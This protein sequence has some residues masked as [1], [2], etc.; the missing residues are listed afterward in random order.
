MNRSFLSN[1]TKEIYTQNQGKLFNILMVLPGNRAKLFAADALRSLQEKKPMILPD[2]LT[3]PEL[4]ELIS[5]QTIADTQDLLLDFYQTVKNID[6][7]I[8]LDQ[9]ILWGDTF[10][11]DFNDIDV[12]LINPKDVFTFLSESKAM[13]LWN[14]SGEALSKFQKRYLALFQRLYEYYNALQIKMNETGYGYQ[15]FVFKN[16][17]T[18][19]NFDKILSQWKKIIFCGFNAFSHSEKTI[20]ER[21]HKLGKL[22]TYWDIDNYYI[23]HPL[24][25]AGKFFRAYKDDFLGRKI[26]DAPQE[27]IKRKIKIR[28]SGIPGDVAQAKVA[29]NIV[30]DLKSHGNTA[31]ILNDE[32]LL[33]PLLNALPKVAEK[34]NVTMGFPAQQTEF[35]QLAE[36]IF[37]LHENSERISEHQKGFQRTDILNLIDIL[38]KQIFIEKHGHPETLFEIPANNILDKEFI[39][40]KFIQKLSDDLKILFEE[41]FSP[42]PDANMLFLSK[43]KN[44]FLMVEKL[45]LPQAN[46]HEHDSGVIF[47]STFI[48]VFNELES[49][50]KSLKESISL[51]TCRAIYK[52][53]VQNLRIPYV[54]EPLE[55]IQVMGMLESRS[56]DFDNIIILSVNEG[57]IPSASSNNTFLPSEIKKTKEIFTNTDVDA[58]YAYNFYRLFHKAENI[59]LLYNAIP[60]RLGTGEKSRFI[61]QIEN[62]LSKQNPNIDFKNEILSVEGDFNIQEQ[63]LRI[64]KTPRII[65]KLIEQCQDK[66]APIHFNTY[67]DCSLKFYFQYV[68]KIQTDETSAHQLDARATGIVTHKVLQ[69]I[70]KPLLGKAPDP[71]FFKEQKNKIEGHVKNTFDDTFKNVQ[72]ETGN[73]F[74][75][76]KITERYLHHYLNNEA[77]R[78]TKINEQETILDTEKKVSLP[79]EFSLPVSSNNDHKTKRKITIKLFGIIDRLDSDNNSV[80]II[81]Y[82]TGK[83]NIN[84]LKIKD[85]LSFENFTKNKTLLQLAIYAYMLRRSHTKAKKPIKAGIS[86]IS[87][88]GVQKYLFIENNNAP[89]YFEDHVIDQIS[90]YIT[91]LLTDIFD[92]D[93][94]FTGTEDKQKCSYCPFLQMCGIE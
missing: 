59:Y 71:L 39:L 16:A 45:L 58:M 25:E 10:I 89:L 91:I 4:A 70:Y 31:I 19:S 32:Q 62:E 67:L 40:N 84:G 8:T 55:G 42:V 83:E 90:E 3:M 2:M 52:K 9:F 80:N 1:I 61:L 92:T 21:I 14:P 56:L 38:F 46:S 49:K 53:Q 57:I 13:S 69:L 28:A 64:S 6:H 75:I 72:T 78:I 22:E 44:V 35:H 76:R 30:K 17:A 85:D 5:S 51:S 12:H 20:L 41:I 93:K 82:K 43:L 50:T 54:G 87:N 34:F 79:F 63:P 60:K 15:G 94:D 88:F 65:D 86:L 18:H 29:C 74:L 37:T 7:N 24:H 27:L 47:I 33:I 11:H 68:C 48:K 26:G 23:D 66:F 73:N 81:D 36:S 77:Q